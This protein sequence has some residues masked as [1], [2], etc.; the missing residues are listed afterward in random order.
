MLA[1]Q[2]TPAFSLTAAR[3][4][5]SP[6]L[7]GRVR[8]DAHVAVFRRA[9]EDEGEWAF[10]PTT[11]ARAAWGAP[12]AAPWSDRHAL[13]TCAGRRNRLERGA[14]M[15]PRLKAFRFTALIDPYSA[16]RRGHAWNR[17]RIQPTPSRPRRPATPI[18]SSCAAASPKRFKNIRRLETK[19]DRE[20]G[21][22]ELVVDD[23][24]P[25]ALDTLIRWKREQFRRTGLHD[26]LHPRW[27]RALMT[28]LFAQREGELR[29]LL[30]TLRAR[31]RI[32]AAHFGVQGGDVYHPWLAAYDAQ[33]AA[34]SP[35]L[36]FLSMVV[37]AMPQAGIARYELSGGSAHYKTAFAS[38]EEVLALGAAEVRSP[39][40]PLHRPLL[41]DR[42]LHRLDHIASTEL[43][44]G[45]RI[46]GVAAALSDI[47]K[48]LPAG[49]R[50][51]AVES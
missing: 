23:T 51:Q 37:R 45:G 16:L 28:T 3:A 1:A 44:L 21:P 32:V 40:P 50:A 15:P 34:H 47:K 43:T 14:A 9:G 46:Q 41:V 25:E 17:A 33:F 39:G 12:S 38:H 7:V 49:E 4:R 8:E 36:V 20:E 5:L 18:G 48:R 29:G 10:W 42:V 35:G 26:V 6:R 24:S 30:I 22:L 31:G 13:I 19:F 27:S 11:A 2:T